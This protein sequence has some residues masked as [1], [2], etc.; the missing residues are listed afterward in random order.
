MLRQQ[1]ALGWA[2]AGERCRTGKRPSRPL[3]SNWETSLSTPRV[4]LG[5]VPLDPST[6]RVELGNVPLDPSTP[7]VELGNAPLD[8]STSQRH[9]STPRRYEH[10]PS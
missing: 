7:L 6:P 2:L 8:L 1:L 3:V 10:M 9:P 5:N 4:E